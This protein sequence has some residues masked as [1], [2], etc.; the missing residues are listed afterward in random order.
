MAPSE[1]LTLVLNF[2]CVPPPFSA[3]TAGVLS[4]CFAKKKVAKEE[5]DPGSAPATRVPCATRRA[6]HP[7]STSSRC[8]APLRARLAKLAAA[9]LKQRQPNPPVPPA[10]LG[11]SHGGNRTYA[12][13]NAF[14]FL[15]FKAVHRSSHYF[16]GHSRESG[17]PEM[18]LIPSPPWIPAFAG[19]TRR[20]ISDRR[21][22]G[23]LERR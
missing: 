18:L 2:C 16:H 5:G 22:S 19:M 21:F 10:L 20:P 23:P 4:S 15:P 9:R 13:R 7:K 1:G 11:A 8:F 14:G 17:N 3:F 12:D 6:G